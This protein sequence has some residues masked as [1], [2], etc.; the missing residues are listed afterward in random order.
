MECNEYRIFITGYIDGEL[1][2][3]ET[4]QLKAHLLTCKACVAYLTRA[5]AM[6]TVLK[7]CVLLQ[8]T[9]DVPPH[10]ARN[11]SAL[12]HAEQKAKQRSIII[13]L[14]QQYRNLVLDAV[15][16][17]TASLRTRPFAWMTSVV[18]ILIVA[19]SL[20]SVNL[21]RSLSQPHVSSQPSHVVAKLESQPAPASVPLPTSTDAQA[22]P[23][24]G[25]IGA[26]AP[27]N[28]VVDNDVRPPVLLAKTKQIPVLAEEQAATIQPRG[29][30][31]Q[32]E[33][34]ML[35]P[36]ERSQPLA[37][38]MSEFIEVTD[39]S[40]I[41]VAANGGKT[42]ESYIYAHVLE[43]AQDQLLDDTVFVGYVQDVLF[44]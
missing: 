17:W 18:G 27:Q 13:R 3:E 25:V 9:P 8:S 38:E 34:N 33:Q 26:E 12:L 36:A 21:V 30:I 23:A 16:K 40:L 39:A 44:R 32:A 41:R 19:V 2:E 35:A 42:P 28:S 6:K 24:R 37:A 14:T 20:A 10:F 7:R 4:R 5:E 15:E 1:S 11:V 43:V 31:A 22:L 29:Q